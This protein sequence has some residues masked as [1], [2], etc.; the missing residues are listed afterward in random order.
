[1]MLKG[2]RTRTRGAVGHEVKLLGVREY[3]NWPGRCT[4]NSR[5]LNEFN[6]HNL[7]IRRIGGI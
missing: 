4:D 1:M 7:F 2:S 5:N 3:I 6:F